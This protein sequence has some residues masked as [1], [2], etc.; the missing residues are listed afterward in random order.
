[1]A[2]A[3][4]H[5]LLST[6]WSHAF[7]PFRSLYARAC[8]DCS[9][10][11]ETYAAE[12]AGWIVWVGAFTLPVAAVVL[13]AMA[14]TA[15]RQPATAGFRAREATL[16]VWLAAHAAMMAVLSPAGVEGWILALVPL[17]ALAGRCL[18]APTV[19]AG[20]PALVLLL[21]AVFVVHNGFAGI[22]VVA[23]EDGDYLRA[24]GG[25]LVE[26]TGPDDL[27]VMAYDWKLDQFLRY[28]GRSRTLL[29]K[30]AG[31]EEARRAIDA[32]L[33]EGGRALIV[34]DLSWAPTRLLAQN[35][36]LAPEFDAL[37][38]DYVG[39]APRSPAGGADRFYEIGSEDDGR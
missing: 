20:R 25:P 17:T 15:V 35:P 34:D 26:R 27:I 28:T 22:G 8:P 37:V 1:M 38:R 29:I 33:A 2:Y 10:V 39:A 7:E 11:E 31:V 12:R 13:A 14:W 30:E 19:A 9:F 23:R 5:D 4:G 21:A 36:T 24:R 3:V 16:V 32:T 6:N 18:V